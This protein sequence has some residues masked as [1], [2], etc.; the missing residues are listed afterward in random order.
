MSFI[1]PTQKAKKRQEARVAQGAVRA[2]QTIIHPA[3]RYPSIAGARSCKHAAPAVKK[4]RKG[5]DQVE[6]DEVVVG[7]AAREP[8][9]SDAA[10]PRDLPPQRV[11]G[12]SLFL[13]TGWH[14]GYAWH[15]GGAWMREVCAPEGSHGPRSSPSLHRAPASRRVQLASREEARSKEDQAALLISSDEFV[16]AEL[17]LWRGRKMTGSLL[18]WWWRGRGVGVKASV[19]NDKKAQAPTKICLLLKQQRSCNRDAKSSE[20]VAKACHASARRISAART[21]TDTRTRR[22]VV[23][24]LAAEDEN[25][26]QAGPLSLESAGQVER[27]RAAIRTIETLGPTR[28]QRLKTAQGGRDST[29]V[30]R[31]SSSWVTRRKGH[32]G[33]SV[34]GGSRIREGVLGDGERVVRIALY[35]RT[36]LVEPEQVIHF[37]D[38][39]RLQRVVCRSE[40]GAI[41]IERE[42]LV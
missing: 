8:A 13:S 14:N 35:H 24:T 9:L 1:E 30:Q 18:L 2:E 29:D 38:K 3:G 33:V 16:D 22:R 37:S 12:P 39:K 4:T 11:A 6:M 32:H 19:V 31:R 21:V 17:N 10:T 34:S 25:P 20:R 28:T 41:I 15:V 27:R 40:I 36:V 5:G 7:R 23:P 42:W 26:K